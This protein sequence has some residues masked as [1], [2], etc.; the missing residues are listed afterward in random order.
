MTEK[1]LQPTVESLTAGK[2]VCWWQRT[3]VCVNWCQRCGW[4]TAILCFTSVH[5]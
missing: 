5:V 4:T 2:T 1:A 3:E